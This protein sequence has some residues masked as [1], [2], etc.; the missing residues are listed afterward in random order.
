MTVYEAVFS[1]WRQPLLA[2]LFLL[3]TGHMALI[4][5]ALRDGWS[6]RFRAFLLAHFSVSAAFF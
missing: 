2:V 1:C 5:A 3:L 6:R 4:F